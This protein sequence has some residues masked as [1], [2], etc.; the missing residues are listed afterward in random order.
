MNKWEEE[1]W[2]CGMGILYIDSRLAIV[3]NAKGQEYASP[4]RFN[5]VEQ[6][7]SRHV[8]LLLLLK[9]YKP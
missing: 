6:I 9:Y 7:T 1:K 8:F 4:S 3:V 5:E 2:E